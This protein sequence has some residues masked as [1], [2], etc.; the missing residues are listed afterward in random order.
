VSFYGQ[1]Y[2]SAWI[3]TNGVLSFVQPTGGSAYN[4]G[5]IP[6]A[7]ATGKANAAVYPMWSDFNVDASA[8]IR[9]A[10]TGTAPN[11]QFVVEWRNVQFFD[12]TAAR[13]S[14]ETVIAENNSDVAVAW[15]NIDAVAIE[16]GGT[17]T[18]G[19]EN[20]AG[21]VALQ[22][23]LNQP[24]LRSGN[25]VLFHPPTAPPPPT[26][27]TLTGRVTVSG[28]GA[29]LAGARIV[30]SPGGATATTAADGTYR[31]DGLTAGAYTVTATAPGGQS[32]SGTATVTA[33]G[34]TLN[35][36]I[37]LTDSFGYTATPGA[38]TFVRADQTVLTLTGDD[39]YQQVALP[40]PVKFYGTTYT[41]VW[42]DT[43]GV[44]TF[45]QPAGSAWNHTAIPSAAAGGKAN[46]AVYPFWEDLNVDASSS[47]RTALVGSAPNRQFVIEWRNVQF[48]ESA[49]TRASFE[50]V[51]SENGDIAV[52]WADVDGTTFE[53]GGSAT[54][55]IE[56]QAGTVALQYSLNQPVL[57]NGNGVL[58]HPPA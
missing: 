9:T 56:N 49:G 32:G 12:N 37:A 33:G 7:A 22:Y 44:A 57:R 10:V 25:G 16:Q 13:V 34:G 1:Q 17:S 53:Q 31:V 29:N 30:L 21:T 27:S 18:V 14:F 50:I 41:S 58:F 5:A 23:S 40:F 48:F 6:S 35:L 28:S 11:R 55:G 51:F 24:N 26:G 54:V 15:N 43:N 19:I 8:S 38:R 20:A 39:N 3:D 45:V 42:V 4:H 36:S 52:A 47:V 46:G 2:T